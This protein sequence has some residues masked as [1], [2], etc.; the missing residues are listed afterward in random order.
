MSH[1]ALR[2]APA[3][4]SLLALLGLLLLASWLG[5]AWGAALWEED[6]Q[7]LAVGLK[8]FPACLGALEGLEQRRAPD[9]RLGVAVVYRDSD[10][11]AREAARVLND[12]GQ[13]RGLPLAVTLFSVTALDAYQG[14]PLSAVF[15][16]SLDLG[17]RRLRAW[18]ERDH[19]LV[20]S[21]FDGDVE[22]G[23]V[24]GIR[25]TDRILPAVNLAQ[26]ARAGLRFKP[27]FL[28]VAHRYE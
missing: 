27:F 24:A 26:A 1:S 23:A 21:P 22:A 15:V 7:R 3:R 11:D 25:V 10:Q 19:L 8:L 2:S 12:I 14:P 9:G 28:Q 6:R 4:V 13:V 16:A 5:W 20:F 18:S 17:S